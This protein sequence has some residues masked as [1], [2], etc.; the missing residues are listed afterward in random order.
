MKQRTFHYNVQYVSPYHY[1]TAI[2]G[3]ADTL[4]QAMGY[5]RWYAQEIE[6][7]GGSEVQAEVTICNPYGLPLK[8]LAVNLPCSEKEPVL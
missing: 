2:G 4:L 8:T 3:W 7:I 1:A 5:C 6:R